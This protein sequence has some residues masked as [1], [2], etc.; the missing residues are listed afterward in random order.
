MSLRSNRDTSD[1]ND[2]NPT[3]VADSPRDRKSVV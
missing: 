2:L 3:G 1:R